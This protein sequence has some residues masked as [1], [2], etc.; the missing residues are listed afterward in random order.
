METVS[1]PREERLEAKCEAIIVRAVPKWS[2]ISVLTRRV[3]QDRAI[4]Q[5]RCQRLG[6][7]RYPCLIP[8][9]TC[10]LLYIGAQAVLTLKHTGGPGA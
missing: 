9:D 1:I 5:R 10:S 2:V 4:L 7:S 6:I 8:S 3:T